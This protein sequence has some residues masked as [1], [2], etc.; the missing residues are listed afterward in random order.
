MIFALPHTK[1]CNLL[2][3]LWEYVNIKL[4]G[5]SP[6]KRAACFQVHSALGGG[7]VRCGEC[8]LTSAVE[9]KKAL[10]SISKNESMSIIHQSEKKKSQE[11]DRVNKDGWGGRMLREGGESKH[12]QTSPLQKMHLCVA[13]IYIY[14]Y[15]IY[16]NIY[17][18][19]RKWKCNG[20]FARKYHCVSMGQPCPTVFAHFHS[21][22][23]D[24]W[25]HNDWQMQEILSMCVAI[26]ACLGQYRC[27]QLHCCLSIV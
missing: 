7:E 14:I 22:M 3:Y 21:E 12:K 18:P 10:K 27:T 11:K 13:T 5:P 26:T 9:E 8:R 1:K 23:R 17:S 4:T 19:E 25:P 6:G 15:C 24:P 2:V 16:I 20:S